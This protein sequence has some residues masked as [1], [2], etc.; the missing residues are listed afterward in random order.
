[1][2]P[3]KEVKLWALLRWSP[4]IL[5]QKKELL[6]LWFLHCL[7]FPLFQCHSSLWNVSL[8]RVQLLPYLVT[9]PYGMWQG[10]KKC[11]LNERTAFLT[12]CSFKLEV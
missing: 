5:P 3:S 1:M 6:T 11:W 2:K 9:Q 8:P 4:R 7:S 10:P 12:L